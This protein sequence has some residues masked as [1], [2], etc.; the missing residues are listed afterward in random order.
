VRVLKKRGGGTT[1]MRKYPDLAAVLE[2][3]APFAGQT[4]IDAGCGAGE[5]VRWL[6][7]RGARAIGLDS[8][9]MLA[10]ARRFPPCGDET[11]IEGSAEKLPF[12]SGSADIIIFQAS[13]HHVPAAA[14]GTAAKECRRVLRR[15]GRAVFIEPV[16]QAGSY[17]DL[18]RLV[19]DEEE[20]QRQARSTITSMAAGGMTMEKEE[21]FFLERSLADYARLL[22]FFVSSPGQRRALSR[23]AG[24]ITA[25]LGA[26]A[27]V[28]PA[29]YRYR[30]ICRLNILRRGSSDEKTTGSR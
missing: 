15:G 18:T 23:R 10:R 5:T 13:F 21:I 27:G 25:A 2:Q 3:A 6:A 12:A 30:S 26:E 14:M 16:Y 8:A 1:A 7:G 22:E 20:A 29:G 9:P 28:A 17:T 4:V 24:K 19:E 11:Y